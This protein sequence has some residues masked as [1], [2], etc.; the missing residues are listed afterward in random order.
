MAICR[1]FS[2][3]ERFYIF[4]YLCTRGGISDIAA[5]IIIKTLVKVS[6][7]ILDGRGKRKMNNMEGG[8]YKYFYNKR[9]MPGM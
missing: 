6:F 9:A 3:S 1:N 4:K 5:R 7:S 8:C 2:S